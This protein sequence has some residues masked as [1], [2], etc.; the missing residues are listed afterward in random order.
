M[1][2]RNRMARLHTLITRG[3]T[4]G[5]GIVRSTYKARRSISSLR[6]AHTLR[7]SSRWPAAVG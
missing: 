2:I 3:Q 1:R 5:R 6:T 4:L 7:A